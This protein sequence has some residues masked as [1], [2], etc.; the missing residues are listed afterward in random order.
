[1][2][3]WYGRVNYDYKSKYLLGLIGRYDGTS[4]LP[5][6]NRW[7]PYYGITAGWVLTE[8]NFLKDASWLNFLKLRLSHGI[9]GNL[10]SLVASG[11]DAPM[12]SS[13]IWIGKDPSRCLPTR[14]RAA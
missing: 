14:N 1:M 9:Q 5:K 10:G 2:A 3:S 11:V 6:N 12:S 7:E 13:Q 4:L 8:E